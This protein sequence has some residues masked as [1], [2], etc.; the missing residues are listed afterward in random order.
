MKM[1]TALETVA[2]VLFAVTIT[3]YILA[4][5]P[6][7]GL[8]AVIV[9]WAAKGGA[10]LIKRR[11]SNGPEKAVEPPE[12]PSRY[13]TPEDKNW[14]ATAGGLLIPETIPVT[15]PSAPSVCTCSDLLA[16]NYNAGRKNPTK[17]CNAEYS[18]ALEDKF[19]EQVR[20]VEVAWEEA[21]MKAHLSQT[22]PVLITEHDPIAE[23]VKQRAA[24][25]AAKEAEASRAA[26][27]EFHK[28]VEFFID[29]YVES[30]ITEWKLNVV[31]AF[32][33]KFYQEEGT[34]ELCAFTG[35][36]ARVVDAFKAKGFTVVYRRRGSET[37][38]E[39]SQ[40]RKYL[41]TRTLKLTHYKGMEIR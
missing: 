10:L 6:W 4:W 31:T 20:Q 25:A 36:E 12:E 30:G 18:G 24:E 26:L 3:C 14:L 9:A 7:I 17:R 40:P 37:P 2:A 19:A 38:V 32:Q 35:P 8:T 34:K 28:A 1:H 22:V 13:A 11:A 27:E 29:Q 41:L 21:K 15:P 5:M 39:Y 23:L 33:T 16:H